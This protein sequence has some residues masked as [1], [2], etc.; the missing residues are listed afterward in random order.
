MTMTSTSDVAVTLSWYPVFAIRKLQEAGYEAFLVGG[1]VR[2]MLLGLPTTDYDIT[3]NATPEQIQALFPDSVYENEFGTVNA[4]LVHLAEQVSKEWQIPV[5][6][7]PLPPVIEIK[8][9][10]DRL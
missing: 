7:L 4:P 6:H 2:D 10:K 3:T 8:K 9:N 5:E 1:A